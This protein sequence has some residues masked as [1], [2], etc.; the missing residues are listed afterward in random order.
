LAGNAM[1][2][3]SSS[4]C[5]TNHLSVTSVTYGNHVVI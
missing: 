2:S 3:N 5:R 4:Y 1:T